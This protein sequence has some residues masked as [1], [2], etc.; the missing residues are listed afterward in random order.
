ML[1]NSL[2]YA[3]FLIIVFILYWFVAKKSSRAQNILILICSYVFY[4]LWDWRFLFLLGFSTALDYFTGIKIHESASNGRRKMWLIISVAINLGFLCFFKYF[5]FF[6][7]SFGRLLHKF[8][9]EPNIPL[10]NIILPVGISF[11]TFHGLSYVFDIYNKKITPTRSLVDY[12]VFV[13]FF[14]L[15][16]AGPIER[17][18]HLLPQVS[19]P[20]IFDSQKATDGM[21]QILWGLFKKIV[22]AD[23]C[24][25]VVNDVFANPDAFSGTSLVIGAILFAFQVYGDFSGYTDIALGSARL[26]GFDLLRNFSYPY[27]SRDIAE[28]WRRWHIS[29]TSWFKDYVYIPLGG[30]RGS[31]LKTVR[32]TIIV[33]LL[34]GVWHGANWTFVVW[35]LYHALL[36]MPLLLFNVKKTHAEP[37]AKGRFS[38]F[39]LIKILVTFGLVTIGWVIFR[40]D[41]LGQAWLYFKDIINP[42]SVEN[43]LDKHPGAITTM[44]FIGILLIIEWFQKHHLHGLYFGGSRFSKPAR[45]IIYSAIIIC[46][47]WF[48]GKPEEFIYFQF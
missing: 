45:F 24:A 16:V 39:D 23:N 38:P 28:F 42:K 34:S 32:N 27:F 18:T 6:V 11:Y 41:T 14:P 25:V 43:I 22:I 8:D 3:A 19:R 31:K 13:S 29:L 10:L 30:N 33:F 5:N 40:A 2:S 20:R 48:G 12:S 46:L 37:I 21:R 47:F 1:F 35:G 9:F 44:I 17:A 36:F 26:L 4:G 7:G 15:L